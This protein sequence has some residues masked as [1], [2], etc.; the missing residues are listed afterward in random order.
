MKLIVY[1]FSCLAA[2]GY[3]SATVQQEKEEIFESD[4]DLA[5]RLDYYRNYS[6]QIT[7]GKVDF[8]AT[9][10]SGVYCVTK[11]SLRPKEFVMKIPKEFISCGCKLQIKIS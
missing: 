1:L 3:I 8:N 6:K 4:E 5:K 11:K 2:I 9:Y 10:G 7:D